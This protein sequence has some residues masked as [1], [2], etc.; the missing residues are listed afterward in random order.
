ME[1]ESAMRRVIK[2]DPT[3]RGYVGDW[4]FKYRLEEKVDGTG[5]AAIVVG[6]DGGWATPQVVNTNEYPR[7]RVD[8]HADLSRDLD[9]TPLQGDAE[10]RAWALWRSVDALLHPG[11]RGQRWGGFGSDPGLLVNTIARGQEP[12]LTVQKDQH[13]GDPP[14]GD[15]AVVSCYYNIDCVH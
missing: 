12:F 1:V 14:L 11:K 10:D 4:V 9:G 7:L 3:V 8:C 2:N 15:T 5:K 6:R 13:A